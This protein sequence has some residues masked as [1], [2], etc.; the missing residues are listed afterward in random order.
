MFSNTFFSYFQIVL[1]I[2][3][4]WNKSWENE[5]FYYIIVKDGKYFICKKD[6]CASFV[7]EFRRDIRK[8]IFEQLITSIYY[9]LSLKFNNDLIKA[10]EI[11]MK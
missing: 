6:I 9:W 2:H 5:E 1:D 10:E 4:S 11:L 7:C 3:S 8:L